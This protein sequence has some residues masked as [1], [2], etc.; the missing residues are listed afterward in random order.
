[1]TLSHSG[2]DDQRTLA[3][4]MFTDVVGFSKLVGQ[5]EQRATKALNRDFDIFYR[6]V[7]QH[8]GEVLNTMGDGMMVVFLSATECM[9]C[10]LAMQ[11]ILHEIAVSAPEDGVL[12][13]RFG[14]HIGEIILK[15]KNTVGDGVN[16][17]ARIQ[18]L[19]KPNA[20]A[21]SRD[22]Y[23]LIKTQVPNNAKYL[24]PVM[25]KNISEPIPIF[26]IPSITEE[27]KQRAA[28]A[29]FSQADVPSTTE[30]TCKKVLLFMVITIVLIGLALLPLF[31]AAQIKKSAKDLAKSDGRGVAE[32]TIKN[33]PKSLENLKAKLSG[34]ENSPAPV[35]AP[36]TTAPVSQQEKF[37]LTPSQ[38]RELDTFVN[39]Y[40][41]Q[42][43][44][45]LIKSNPGVNTPE[46][47]SAVKK[48]ESLQ[49]FKDWIEREIAASTSE[50]PILATISGLEVKVFPSKDGVVFESENG[51]NVRPLWE[52]K[53][54]TIQQLAETLL[55]KPQS[56]SGAPQEAPVWLLNFKELHRI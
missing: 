53:P 49:Q 15:G 55:V 10:A 22:F 1:M 7:S 11:G 14:L 18:T 20:I 17:A 24:G 41:Y 13:H 35:N 32:G 44:V 12:E 56:A 16:Q 33:D 28:E 21:M 39:V 5:N 8:N 9:K 34:Q 50:H 19:A 52:Y 3:S 46:G 47:E 4:I 45:A 23:D 30:V 42:S 37:I 25:T 27:M 40:D 38:L 36:A 31:F 6:L 29:M 54:T 48:Y 51:P 43:A 26:E 2:S